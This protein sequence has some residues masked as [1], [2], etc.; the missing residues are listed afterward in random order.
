VENYFRYVSLFGNVFAP[1]AGVLV[2]DYLFVRRMR[3]DVAALYDAK[4]PYRYW[5]GFNLTAIA[6]TGIGFLICTFVIPA[7]WIPALLTSL[8]TGAGYAL[9]VWL[10]PNAASVVPRKQ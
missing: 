6:W 3:I 5:E 9:T 8:V 7:A 4:G 1:V 2:F 10:L